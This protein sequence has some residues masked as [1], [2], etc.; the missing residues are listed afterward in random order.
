M[1]EAMAGRKS[2]T[3]VRKRRLLVGASAVVLLVGISLFASGTLVALSTDSDSYSS[4]DKVTVK[5]RNT[6]LRQV[7]YNLCQ[8]FVDLERLDDVGW[9]PV[10]KETKFCTAEMRVIRPLQSVTSQ[11]ELPAGL[12]GGEYRLK[13]RIRVGTHGPPQTDLYSDVFDVS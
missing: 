12:S 7:G 3:S 1:T 6:S 5:L 13:H 10:E 4:G 11:F 2:S 8:S 9:E